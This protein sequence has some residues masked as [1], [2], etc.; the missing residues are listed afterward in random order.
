V[1]LTRTEFDLLQALT[2]GP[3]QVL[4]R[5]QL[6]E[7]VWGPDWYGDERSVDLHIS[8]LRAKLGDNPGNPRYILTVR[9]VG[10]RIGAGEDR[11]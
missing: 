4:T 10:F 5:T 3:R 2:A 6:L 9:G 11:R 8:H 1:E 7:S